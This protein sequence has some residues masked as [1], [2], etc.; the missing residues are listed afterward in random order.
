M[1]FKL[2]SGDIISLSNDSFDSF[3]EQLETILQVPRFRI[4]IEIINESNSIV[5]I[6]DH[7]HKFQ[8]YY[9]GIMEGM[10]NGEYGEY[11]MYMLRIYRRNDDVSSPIKW[12]K[13]E[14]SYYFERDKN[15]FLIETDTTFINNRDG[16]VCI[17][18]SKSYYTLIDA[19]YNSRIKDF[20]EIKDDTFKYLLDEINNMK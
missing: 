9:L 2:M 19:I 3:I 15:H 14:I 1:F 17:T 7:P 10:L 18:S 6:N 4:H 20:K 12:N 11:E 13:Y 5:L 8:K 16:D